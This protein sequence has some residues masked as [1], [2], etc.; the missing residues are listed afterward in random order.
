MVTHMYTWIFMYGG[1]GS[2]VPK[3]STCTCTCTVQ[4]QVLRPHPFTVRLSCAW[5]ILWYRTRTYMYV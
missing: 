3:Y 5:T 4:L 1:K 2:V